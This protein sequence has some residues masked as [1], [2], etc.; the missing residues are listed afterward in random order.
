MKQLSNWVEDDAAD[1]V[2]TIQFGCKRSDRPPNEQTDQGQSSL[3][4]RTYAG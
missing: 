1:E 2:R 4:V 3:L